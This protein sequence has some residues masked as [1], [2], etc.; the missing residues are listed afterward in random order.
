VGELV[1]EDSS[2]EVN[3][4]GLEVRGNGR[5]TAKRNRVLGNGVAIRVADAGSGVIQD[6]VLAGNHKIWK[7]A[8]DREAH[9]ERA[10]NREDYRE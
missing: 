2:L 8:R 10:R 7:I 9:V 6:N 1:L 4:I 5:I 3:T